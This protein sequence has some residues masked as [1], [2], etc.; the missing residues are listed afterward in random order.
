MPRWRLPPRC[1]VSAEDIRDLQGTTPHGRELLERQGI[2][3]IPRTDHLAQN[4][5]G[6]LHIQRRGIQPMYCST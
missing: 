4:V 2:Q 6:H 1:P 3:R 5:R